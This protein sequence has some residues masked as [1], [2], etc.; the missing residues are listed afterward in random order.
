MAIQLSNDPLYGS[1]PKKWI[2][3]QGKMMAAEKFVMNG[4]LM[5]SVKKITQKHVS[6]I[7]T[8]ERSCL[9]GNVT[10]L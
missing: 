7:K 1:H 2:S 9:S 10:M 6:D 8:N 3:T 5:C 4:V